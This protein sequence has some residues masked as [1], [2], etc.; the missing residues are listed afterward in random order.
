M[1]LGVFVLVAAMSAASAVV[2]HKAEAAEYIVGDQ[3]GWTVPSHR[4]G[5]GAAGAHAFY[6]SWAATHRFKPHD[7]IG[8]YQYFYHKHACKGKVYV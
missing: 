7:T 6:A 2:L 8:I 1:N 5:D 4:Q 3:V